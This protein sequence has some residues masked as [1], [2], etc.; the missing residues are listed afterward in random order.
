[1]TGVVTSVSGCRLGYRIHRPGGAASDTAVI[2]GHGFLGSKEG[3]DGLA[4][5]LAQAGATAV[6]LDFCNSRLWDG[7]HVRNGLDMVGLAG[8]LGARRVIYGGFSAGALAA[9]VAGQQDPN[10]LGVVA[11][12]PVDH[13][14]LG[15]RMAK[16]LARPLIG[17][18]GE[19]SACNANGNASA[20][21][22]ASRRGQVVRVPGAS[23]CDFEDP[24]DGLCEVVCG[25]ASGNIAVRRAIIDAA[26]AAVLQLL[27]SAGT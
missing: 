12:D 9:L 26:V 8:G 16:R 19:P 21:L 24:G 6:T 14:G 7:R 17:I 15:V 18:I 4:T 1:M 25:R 3:M 13:D 2:L 23:H 27:R 10:A 5:A 22:A 11:L 20:M